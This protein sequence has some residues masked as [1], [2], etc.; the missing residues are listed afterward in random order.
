MPENKELINMIARAICERD[1]VQCQCVC[2]PET[3]GT[4]G[5]CEGP[6][7]DARAVLE[8]LAEAG[9]DLTAKEKLEKI[10]R[11]YN[12]ETKIEGIKGTKCTHARYG[13]EA[14]IYEIEHGQGI[15]K[16]SMATLNTVI[17]QLADI[18]KVLGEDL[19][20]VKEFR[21]NTPK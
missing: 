16:I 21:P 11:I 3:R 1:E 4:M 13:L 2:A 15:D 7:A 18:E 20:W 12:T 5:T 6:F 19:I 10:A 17:Q 8:C 9:I 14:V